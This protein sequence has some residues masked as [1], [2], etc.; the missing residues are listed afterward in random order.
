MVARRGP[1]YPFAADVVTPLTTSAAL[2]AHR[3]NLSAA[4]NAGRR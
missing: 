3:H 2:M 4:L 1:D